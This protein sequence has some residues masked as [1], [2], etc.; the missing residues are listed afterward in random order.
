MA[1]IHWGHV[2]AAVPTQKTKQLVPPLA[3]FLVASTYVR[4]T[5]FLPKKA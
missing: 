4:R 3:D 1:H 2:A 5:T